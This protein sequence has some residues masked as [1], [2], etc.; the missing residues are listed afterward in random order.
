MQALE[1]HVNIFK[2]VLFASEPLPKN[3]ISSV[4]APIKDATDSLASSIN[5]LAFLP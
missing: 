1:K 5:F 4:S 3:I 2:T